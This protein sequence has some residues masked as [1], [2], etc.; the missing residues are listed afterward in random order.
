[1]FGQARLSALPVLTQPPQEPPPL[2]LPPLL[3]LLLLLLPCRTA[4]AMKPASK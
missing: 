1:L 2:L 3:L 4:A